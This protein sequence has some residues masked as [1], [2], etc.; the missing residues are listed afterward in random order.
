MCFGSAPKAPPSP[1]PPAPPINPIEIAPTEDAVA[2]KKRKK[3]GASML[4]IPLA[5]S[6][7]PAGLGIPKVI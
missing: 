3:L 5:G 7:P 2:A 6:A 1:P 4:Q